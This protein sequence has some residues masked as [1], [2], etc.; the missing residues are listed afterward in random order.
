MLYF[1]QTKIRSKEPTLMIHPQASV[2]IQP[3]SLPKL[4]VCHLPSLSLPPNP[5]LNHEKSSQTQIFQPYKLPQAIYVP[6]MQPCGPLRPAPSQ[7]DIVRQPVP[8]IRNYPQHQL[9]DGDPER[10]RKRQENVQT[11]LRMIDN[12][13]AYSS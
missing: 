13:L 6:T 4:S 9:T 8:D 2:S 12:A 3:T 10:E 11:T 7:P 1:I 5:P